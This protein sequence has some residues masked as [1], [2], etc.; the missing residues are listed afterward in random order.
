M[1]KRDQL[2]T[3][4]ERYADARDACREQYDRIREDFKF[5][6]PACPQQWDDFAT[7]ARKGR[8]MHTLDR[9]NQFVQHY[10]NK[11]RES[12]TS[13]D[14][15]PADSNADIQTAKALKGMIRHIE[16]TS[17]AD[18][19]WDTAS[20]HQARGGLGWVRILPKIVNPE[21]N[22]QEI[23]IQR[24][25]DPL[26]C[27]LDPDSVEP[28]GADS[29]YAFCEQTLTKKAF[30]RL[31]PKKKTESFESDGWY[32][33]D[34]VR[35]A[36]YF[37]VEEEKV[38]NVTIDGPEGRITISEDEYWTLA[39]QIGYKPPVAA[40]FVGKKRIVKWCKMSGAEILE[41]TEFPSQWI[42]LVPVQGHELWVEGKKYLCGLVRRLMDGQRLHNY[43]MSALTEALMVQ[44]KAPFMLSNR[45]IDGHE[46]EWQRLNSGNPAYLTYNDVDPDSDRPINAPQRLSP[47]NYPAAYA[48]SAESAVREMEA[49]VG[50]HPSLFG[51][52]SRSV[53]GRAK[54]A[55]QQAG[56]TATFHFADNRR[57]SQT[58]AYRIVVDM[59]PR[60]YDSS[61]QARILGEDGEQSTVQI[62]TQMGSASQSRNGKL[63]AINP[64]VGRYDVRVKIGPS[65]TTIREELGVK[66]Q[67]MSKGNPAFATA[68]TPILMQLEGMPEADK[69]ARIALAML[70]PEV[71]KAYHDDDTS[72]IP[73]AAK[74]QIGE[75]GEQIQ[76]MAQAM[77]QASK[78][79]QDLQGQIQ[80]KNDLV[81][82]EAKTAMTEIQAAQK[83]LKYQAEAVKVQG[84]ELQ[85]TKRIVELELEV[86]QM[87]KTRELENIFRAAE[88]QKDSEDSEVD[89]QAISALAALQQAIENGNKMLADQ[90]QRQAQMMATM[91]TATTEALEEL[92]ESVTAK[93]EITLHRD[94]T[95]K[96]IGATSVATGTV[97]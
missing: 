82:A 64:G 52:G 9:T 59:L 6:N 33:E 56:E 3:A 10:V 85:D 26:S 13:A 25:H 84:R 20:D 40:T 93:R 79:I 83:E 28:D 69:V 57:V 53:S 30:E 22:E 16:Y 75:M 65:F 73:P 17:R 14:I 39:Q 50:M 44:P 92:A 41:E 76:Q 58:Q 72:E 12:K 81:Q 2:Q 89:K 31:Y 48:Q 4:R 78:V 24:V 11:S 1:A 74:A 37:Y 80:E 35:I 43:E 7:T 32:G 88:E 60:V 49:S 66:I 61:R 29:N 63:V 8:P 51:Q 70:P 54:I 34:G 95:G 42:G 94:K 90:L 45:A 5:S 23:L 18:I 47:P 21:T 55:D 68:I 46:D 38:N 19:A 15:L 62:N 77:E 71:Q 96:P 36:E 86:N 87:K 91:S 27:M 67:E 97:Q